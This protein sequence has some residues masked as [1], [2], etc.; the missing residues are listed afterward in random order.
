[1]SEIQ[2]FWSIECQESEPNLFVC[3]SCLDE[4]Y[5]SKIP[6]SCP[7]CRNV[8][9][10]E[11]FTLDAIKDW[12]TNKLIAKAHLAHNESPSLLSSTETAPSELTQPLNDPSA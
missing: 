2:E 8:S 12:G 9:T 6:I 10:F 1:M 11:A 5:R 3:M 4:V 7:T